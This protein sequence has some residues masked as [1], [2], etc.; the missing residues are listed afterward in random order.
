MAG[1]WVEWTHT[2][3]PA[4][5]VSSPETRCIATSKDNAPIHTSC[6]TTT[7]LQDQGIHVLLGWPPYSPD[8]NPIEHM[9][10]RLK[11]ILYELYPDL[12]DPM[13]QDQALKRLQQCQTATT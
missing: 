6:S 1:R 8:L 5:D 9:W 12:L 10:A 4:D 2:Q 11:D 13:P 3:R 7:W